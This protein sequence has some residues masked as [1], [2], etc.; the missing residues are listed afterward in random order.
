MDGVDGGHELLT[1]GLAMLDAIMFCMLAFFFGIH[2][3]FDFLWIGFCG[4]SIC[5]HSLSGFFLLE[6]CHLD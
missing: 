6:I 1:S 3:S 2:M 4:I 5:W